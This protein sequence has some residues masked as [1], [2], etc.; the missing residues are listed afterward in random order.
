MDSEQASA[1]NGTQD[2]EMK[3]NSENKEEKKVR[4]TT[5]TL[6]WYNHPSTVRLF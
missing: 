2:A 5:L 1:E 6:D 4:L 3:E